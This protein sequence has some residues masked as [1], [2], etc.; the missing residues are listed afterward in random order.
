MSAA[1]KRQEGGT[2]YATDFWQTWN[3]IVPMK[4]SAFQFEIINYVDR[5]K[6]KNGIEDLKKARHWLDKLI[7]I[8]EGRLAEDVP[9]LNMSQTLFVFD[10]KELSKANFSD[11][12][13]TLTSVNDET[14]DG[15]GRALCRHG[16]LM[17]QP[18]EAC[19]RD[20]KQALK[21]ADETVYGEHGPITKYPDGLI[22]ERPLP[23]QYNED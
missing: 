2:H 5:Y 11:A 15:L 22:N 17:T 23:K 18:C 4:W 10:G 7:E 8:E 21:N 19:G 3:L 20:C 9:S 14:L 16:P 12:E 13:I 1:D 6:R